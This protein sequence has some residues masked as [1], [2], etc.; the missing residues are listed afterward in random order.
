MPF[1]SASQKAFASTPVWEDCV[2]VSDEVHNQLLD[3]LST[4]P[5]SSLG[6]DENGQPIFVPAPTPAAPTK[7]EAFRGQIQRLNMDYEMAVSQ[8]RDTYPQAE[9][10]TWPVQLAEA[11]SYQDWV[12]GGS[13]GDAPL[14]PFLSD[15]SAA[16]DAV[17]VGNGLADLVSRILNNDAI[18]S[19]AIASLTARRHKAEQD[20]YL[21]LEAGEVEDILDVTWD[22]TLTL[23][24]QPTVTTPETE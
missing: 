21:A 11:K 7:S 5:G 17:G 9:T 2:E 12:T 10:S 22:F 8:L 1:F 16:R 4:N 6:A 15:L 24:E 23:P 20:L 19:P 18:Y 14:T 13:V 3:Q